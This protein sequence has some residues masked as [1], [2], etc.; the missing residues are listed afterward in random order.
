LIARIQA[1]DTRTVT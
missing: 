1:I